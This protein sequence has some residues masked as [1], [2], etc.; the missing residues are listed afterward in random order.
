MTARG[1]VVTEVRHEPWLDWAGGG[2]AFSPDGRYFWAV[3][4][5]GDERA[6]IVEVTGCDSWQVVAT[7]EFEAE[8]DGYWTVVPHPEGEVAGLWVGAGQDGQW[9]YWCGIQDDWLYVEE[10]PALAW[11]GPPVFHPAG[12]EFLTDSLEDELFRRH[13]FPDGRVIGQLS[14]AE[15]FPPDDSEE[16]RDMFGG[17]PQYLSDRRAL[18]LSSNG[19]LR[20]LDLEAMRVEGDPISPSKATPLKPHRF[21][22]GQAGASLRGCGPIPRP[23][24][25]ASRHGPSR[26]DRATPEPGIRTAG[27]GRI[28]HLRGDEGAGE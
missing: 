5:G 12:G 8:E 6:V 17:I 26:L 3:R 25:R 13:R 19:R 10:E 16:D 22:R 20:L 11:T 4:C 7:E 9:L 24:E 1:E 27:L 28:G 18:V 23:Q 15:I 14:E 2:C 21:R